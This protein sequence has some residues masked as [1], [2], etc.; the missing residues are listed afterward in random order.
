MNIPIRRLL[1]SSGALR[2]LSELKGELAAAVAA[3]GERRIVT[4]CNTG[5]QASLLL[6]G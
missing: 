4:Y 5:L 1:T 3:S 2:P 6:F